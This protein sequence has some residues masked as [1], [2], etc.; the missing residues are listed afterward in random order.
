MMVD[1]GERQTFHYK[2]LYCL[3]FV[4]VSLVKK[5]KSK[6]QYFQEFDTES[7]DTSS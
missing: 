2:L 1:E 6:D 4:T 3:I 5:L 7:M